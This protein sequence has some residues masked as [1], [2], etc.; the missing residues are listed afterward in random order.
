MPYIIYCVYDGSIYSAIIMF[1]IKPRTL[2]ASI[3]V[4]MALMHSAI[5][6]HIVNCMYIT[7]SHRWLYMGQILKRWFVL[8]R[9]SVLYN[10]VLIHLLPSSSSINPCVNCAWV[11]TDCL[12]NDCI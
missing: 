7:F 6:H 5:S 9:G 10:S 2:V 3:K 4:M 12:L 1:P 8:G 11:C